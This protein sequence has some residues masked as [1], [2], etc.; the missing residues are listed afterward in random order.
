[1][2]ANVA[3]E[4]LLVQLALVVVLRLDQPLVVVERELRV[5][6]DQLTGAHHG[7]DPVAGREGVLDRVGGGR[8]PVAEEVLEQELAEAAA[9]LRRPERLLQ[10]RE[11]LRALEHL[12]CRAVDLA[13]ALVDRRARL[14][15]GLEPPVDL[16][17]EVAEPA[18]DGLRQLADPAVDVGRALRELVGRIGAP[19][20]ELG[21]RLRPLGSELGVQQAQEKLRSEGQSAE[22]EDSDD[23]DDGCH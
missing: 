19:R 10:A 12:G 13:E 7:V 2:V 20:G 18:V 22:N 17:V 1:M 5:D 15:R 4:R 11:V 6:G 8:Q 16:L 9:C 3:G 14:L 21:V 23:E